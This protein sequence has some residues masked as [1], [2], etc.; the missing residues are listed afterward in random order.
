M[1]RQ[2]E[3][4]RKRLELQRKRE[5]MEAQIAATRAVFETEAALLL[6]MLNDDETQQ[7]TSE[8]NREAM[9]VS[10]SGKGTRSLGNGSSKKAGKS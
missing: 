7:R 2:Q 10:R 6:G 3:M 9:G 8:Q 5:A 1:S 4:S